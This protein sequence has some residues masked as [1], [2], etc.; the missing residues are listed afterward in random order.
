MRKSSREVKKP[1]LFQFVPRTSKLREI[2]EE[3]DHASPETDEEEDL[4]NDK[5][6]AVQKPRVIK[7]PARS[8][9]VASSS[10]AATSSF[11]ECKLIHLVLAKIGSRST[12]H[13]QSN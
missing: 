12:S 13:C 5:Q 3:N 10:S 1:E 8:K 11:G 2:V 9:A 6:I 4:F 7:G